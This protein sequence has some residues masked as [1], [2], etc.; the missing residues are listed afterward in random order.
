MA[1][2][3]FIKSDGERCQRQVELLSKYCWQHKPIITRR[4]ISRG[5]KKY[6]RKVRE[7]AEDREIE[8]TSARNVYSTIEKIAA[9]RIERI[10]IKSKS[11]R[12][13]KISA[14]AFDAEA[15]KKERGREKGKYVIYYDALKKRVVDGKTALR[16]RYRFRVERLARALE[17]ASKTSQGAIVKR[18]PK[19]ARK[20]GYL[21]PKEAEQVAAKL[22]KEMRKSKKVFEMV[23]ARGFYM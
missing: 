17:E 15:L 12:P 14:K 3:A 20:R 6:W 13:R 11:K 2:C 8:L 7:I 1:R 21:L 22:L 19:K 10:V 23:K 18:W 5:V 4:K 16:M 9:D